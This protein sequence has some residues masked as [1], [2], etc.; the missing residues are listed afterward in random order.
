MERQPFV[1]RV[2]AAS[3]LVQLAVFVKKIAE[4]FDVLPS[5]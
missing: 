3:K 1:R 2:V 5:Y 4:K